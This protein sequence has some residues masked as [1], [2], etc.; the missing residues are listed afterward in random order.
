MKRPSTLL[1]S[2]WLALSAPSGLL[3]AQAADTGLLGWWLCA[4]NHLRGSTLNAF[5]GGLAGQLEGGVHLRTDDGPAFLEFD[6]R[7]SCLRLT[8]RLEDATL[9][10]RALSVETWVVV[11]KP[12]AWGGIIGALQDNGDFERGWLLGYVNNNFAIALAS[13]GRGRMT[14]LE[15]REPFSPGV[16][17]HVVGTYDGG[18]LR[19]YVDGEPAAESREQSGKILYPPQAPYVIGAYQDENEFYGLEGRIHE[20]R[21]FSRALAAGEIQERY[22]AMRE[23]F[24]QPRPPRPEFRA[25]TG[26]FVDWVAP[27]A[28][29]VS[30]TTSGPMPSV[31]EFIDAPDRRRRFEDATP[32]TQH[33]FELDEI[34]RDTI[35]QYR[36]MGVDASGAPWAS[37]PYHFDSTFNY[38]VPE[39][40]E[41]PS[42]Y[43]DTDWSRA[44][45]AAAREMIGRLGSDQG[46]A[47][48]LGAEDGC[49]AY[50]LAKQSRLSVVVLEPDEARVAAIR[51]SLDRAGFYGVRVAVQRGGLETL[52]YGKYFANL[53]VSERVLRTGA[54]PPSATEAFRCLR[55]NG[56]LVVMAQPAGSGAP[57]GSAG[58]LRDW[59]AAG[60]MEGA[61]IEVR[62]AP[63]GAYRRPA[64]EG[65]GDWSHLYGATDNSACSKDDL[66]QG[67]MGVLWWGEPGP[68][69][70]P[71]RGPRN[72]SSVSA[73][74]RLFVQGDRVLFGIDAYNGSILWSTQAPEVRRANMPRDCS[75][76]AASSDYLYVA[77]GGTLTG[78]NGQ[79]G[80]RELQFEVPR[81]GE[82]PAHD[83][84]Y[85]GVV[86]DSVVGSAVKQGSA[87]IGD[88]GEWYD[89]AGVD[90]VSVV[91]SD[92]L[93]S[94]DRHNGA[95]EW[96]YEGG[97]VINSTITV[98]DGQV[99][100]VESRNAEAREAASGRLHREPFTEQALVA[101]DLKSGR[102]LWE[103]SVDFGSAERMLYLAY[104]N[105]TLTAVGGAKDGYHIWA[106]DVPEV[107]AST[108][109]PD[110]RVLIGDTKLWEQH[111]PPARDH[112][113]GFIQHPLI[114][115]DTLYSERRAFDLRTGRQTRDDLPDRRGCGTMAASSHSFFYRHHF[116]GQ[117]DLDTNERKQFEGIRGGCWLSLIPSGGLVL[118]PET[119]AGCSCTHAIQTSVA[120]AP[121]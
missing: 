108:D 32:R 21:V 91:T 26:P 121:R 73:N 107:P 80:E 4:P 82:E 100:F 116:H 37:R 120:Y 101:L 78:I 60:G 39:A 62:N 20:V 93:F 56:G 33:R 68:R 25:L 75:N 70:M 72:P 87:Y 111:Y 30:W 31:L 2:G 83:W 58:A 65:A 102:K 24:P 71:D 52:P 61:Q 90:E 8:D 23:R 12:Q 119:S 63:W 114:V 38:L 40:P 105:G 86:G 115:G 88:D 13:E 10:D 41:R 1:F 113:G 104:G 51:R 9:P 76:M 48:V 49:L 17:H 34:P 29:E 53:L 81:E 27:G 69:P 35:C 54:L 95:R 64:L 45:A 112:H 96:V 66:V 110:T 11:A 79:T 98:A 92:R 3:P 6:G 118:A 22:T 19:L 47:L 97:T 14:Y 46:Y 89:G 74:G 5:R 59:F 42:P 109:T 67:E 36:L 94:L 15:S 84:G 43:A 55:P 99:F 7:R 18:W 77:S 106:Y 44:C 50:E 16:W 103:Q 85:V 28:I 57:A 117:W